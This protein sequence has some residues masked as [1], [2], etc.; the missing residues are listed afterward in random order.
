MSRLRKKWN[1]RAKWEKNFLRNE[2]I[3]SVITTIIIAVWIYKGNGS[4]V[5]DGLLKGSR[6]SVYVAL[7][8]I[9][10]SLLGFVITALSIIIGYSANDKLEFLR[11]TAPYEQLWKVL[12]KTIRA[13]S[14]ATGAMIVGLVL[15]RD[16]APNHI[17]FCIC[18][19][20]IVLSLMRLWRCVWVLENVIGIII[21]P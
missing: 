21:Q 12:L 19:Y 5:V 3:L 8:A 14:L 1:L 9:L 10:G 20:T 7:A 2:F 15:D 6:S 16:N 4:V 17:I 13:L 18:V 11:K